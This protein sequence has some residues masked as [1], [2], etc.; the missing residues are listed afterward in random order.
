VAK[1]TANLGN[2]DLD[3]SKMA[4]MMLR[5]LNETAKEEHFTGLGRDNGAAENIEQ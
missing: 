1:P 2:T 5:F 3:L 4:P